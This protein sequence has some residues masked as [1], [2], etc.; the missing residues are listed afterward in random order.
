[1]APV[2]E[3]QT[4]GT[5]DWCMRRNN[6]RGVVSGTVIY[7]AIAK[8]NISPT[9]HYLGRNKDFV[10]FPI[11]PINSREMSVPVLHIFDHRQET[12]KAA[13]LP[14]PSGGDCYRLEGL[15]GAA[16]RRERMR[17]R[18]VVDVA[19]NTPAKVVVVKKIDNSSE[20]PIFHINL[21]HA[22]GEAPTGLFSVHS[23]TKKRR[24][25]GVEYD[26]SFRNK[27]LTHPRS[28]DKSVIISLT[29][30]ERRIIMNG[31]RTREVTI[32][33]GSIRTELKGERSSHQED[34]LSIERHTP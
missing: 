11:R 33:G 15:Q 13:R 32:I 30:E 2:R 1:M 3:N 29:S 5:G 20:R 7:W 12:I 16:A 34:M 6:R 23:C 27:I 28:R 22:E 4:M 24:G 14:V 10:C 18:P 21:Y 26:T 17:R 25:S 9:G 8:V 19:N 31:P